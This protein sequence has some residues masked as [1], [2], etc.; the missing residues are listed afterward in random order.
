MLFLTAQFHPLRGVRYLFP[1]T[2]YLVL[3]YATVLIATE[4]FRLSR[5]EAFLSR[6][7]KRLFDIA[8]D[9]GC[10]LVHSSPLMMRC[11]TFSAFALNLLANTGPAL[12][13][14]QNPMNRLDEW[15]NQDIIAEQIGQYRRDAPE[16]FVCF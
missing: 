15:T 14:R 2:K 16:R 12:A 5:S 4:E 9:V 10:H 7:T 3:R 11:E 8:S 13:Q 6:R 1:A